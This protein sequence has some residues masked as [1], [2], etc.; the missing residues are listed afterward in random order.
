[1]RSEQTV[2]LLTRVAW[3]LA[4]VRLGSIWIVAASLSLLGT[5]KNSKAFELHPISWIFYCPTYEVQLFFA[6]LF[7]LSFNSLG[8]PYL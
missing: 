6:L 8:I 5:E 4:P 7:C 2:R 1:M 3:R